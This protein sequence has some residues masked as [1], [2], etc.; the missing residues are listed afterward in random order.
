MKEVIKH[1]KK[2]KSH[3]INPL[4]K[5]SLMKHIIL[6]IKSMKKTLLERALP[7]MKMIIQ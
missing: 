5:K 4:Q 6:K 3:L 7:F 1:L 2:R